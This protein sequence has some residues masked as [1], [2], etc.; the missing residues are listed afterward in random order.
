MRDD[1]EYFIF[2]EMEKKKEAK[3][4]QR[5]RQR[6]TSQGAISPKGRDESHIRPI[7]EL[8]RINP[9]ATLA[10]TLAYL[11]SK[12]VTAASRDIEFTYWLERRPER[13]DDRVNQ[14]NR[15]TTQRADGSQRADGQTT[16]LSD[17]KSKSFVLVE[18]VCCVLLAGLLGMI[19]E[20]VRLMILGL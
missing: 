14:E 7:R 6:R 15:P 13:A 8:L 11:A 10:E 12:K 20:L 2:E 9:Q 16:N 18:I 1:M 3:K 4:K 17:K 19:W 5:P